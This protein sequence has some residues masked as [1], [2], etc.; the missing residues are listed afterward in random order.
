MTFLNPKFRYVGIDFETTGLDTKN[1]SP[2]QIGIVELNAQGEIIDSFE[3]LVKPDK[4]ISELKNI[5]SFI[6]KIKTAELVFAPTIADIAQEIQHFFTPNTIIIGHNISFDICFLKRILPNVEFYDSF[7]TFALSQTLIPYPPS[8]ALEILLS[9]LSEKPLF[10]TRKQKFGLNSEN[11]TKE[12]SS[13]S[14]ENHAFHDAFYDTKSALALFCYL[15]EFIY[16]IINSTPNIKYFFTKGQATI[17]EILI[18]S[19]TPNNPGTQPFLPPLKKITPANTSLAEFPYDIQINKYTNMSR[20]YVGS[21]NFKKLLLSLTCNKKIMLVFANKPKLDIA[22]NIFFDTGLKNIGFAREEQTISG[23]KFHNFLEKDSFEQFE[24]YF[25]LKYA[26]H[27]FYGYGV[28]DLNSKGDYLV[29]N[30][31]KDERLVIN[32]PIVLTTHHGLYTIL[33]N[34]AHAY[35][36]YDIVFFDL[37]WRYKNYNNYLSRSCDLYYIQNFL[38]MMLYK[39]NFGKEQKDNTL[40]D[41]DTFWT[42][43]MGIIWEECK[44]LF[45]GRADDDLTVNPINGNLDFYQTNKLLPKLQ[46]FEQSLQNILSETDFLTLWKQIKHFLEIT[47]TITKITRKTYGNGSE[48]G[49]YFLFAEEAKFTNRE[50]FKEIFQKNHAIFLSNIEQQ[51]TLLKPGITD[52]NDEKVF[53]RAETVGKLETLLQAA[54]SQGINSIF[55]VSTQKEESRKLFETMQKLQSVHG[56]ELLVENIT[57]GA[58][59]NIHKAKRSQ[60]HLMI[61]GYNFLMMCYAQKLKFDKMFVRNVRGA[62]SNGILQDMKWYKR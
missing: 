50:E 3:S 42:M 61:G 12:I 51:Y 62:Q 29:Y 56:Y 4:E 53:E 19:N 38:D 48:S 36:D 46:E 17:C 21:L 37:E 30:L 14:G 13:L 34:E 54:T 7:D 22:K 32:Y 20:Y 39:Y 1:D 27:L 24:I 40:Q 43:F 59:K 28:L 26:T 2:I 9:H 45:L 23:E 5:V 47:E 35:T 8:Y 60:L 15:I 33:E 58:G 25:I 6:T 11:S 18:L 16:E 55:I 57:G 52:I 31:I 41:F 49:F 44:K 10:I